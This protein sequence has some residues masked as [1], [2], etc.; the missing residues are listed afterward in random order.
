MWVGKEKIKKAGVIASKDRLLALNISVVGAAV[1]ISK[2][3][4]L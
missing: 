1:T 4:F 2:N 3:L